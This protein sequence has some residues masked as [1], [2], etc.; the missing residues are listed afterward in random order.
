MLLGEYLIKHKKIDEE[1]LKIALDE[2]A[3]LTHHEKLGEV[4][5]KLGFIKRQVLIEA[6]SELDPTA[7]VG[8]KHGGTE[9]PREYLK[10]TR[11]VIRADAGR[12]IF[13]ST[14]HP[15]PQEVVDRLKKTTNREVRL[16]PAELEWMLDTCE[17]E[18]GSEH[19]EEEPVRSLVEETDINKVLRYIIETANKNRASDIHLDPTGSTLEVRLRIDTM[20]HHLASLTMSQA[21]SLIARIKGLA[22][23]MDEAQTRQ[24]QDGSFPFHCHGQNIDLRV[25][26]LP[27]LNGEKLTLRLLNKDKNLKRIEDVGLSKL[28]EWL[29]LAAQRNGLILVCGPTGSG[30]TTTL[31]STIEYQ[32]RQHKAVF[33]IEDPIEYQLPFVTQV[34]INPDMGMTFNSFTKY[35]MRHDP[36]MVVVGE[37]RDKETAD[38]SIYLATTGH[39]VYSTLHTG[40]VSESINRLLGMEVDKQLLSFVLRGILVQCLVRRICPDC[41]KKIHEDGKVGCSTCQHTGYAGMSLLTE[42]ARL[43]THEDVDRIL[44]GEL[45]IYTYAQD[46]IAKVAAGVT[47]CEEIR[48]VFGKRDFHAC[49][50]GECLVGSE[51]NVKRRAA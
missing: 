20:V 46:A 30:K 49:G 24:A 38:N 41:R 36:D 2:Q 6:L 39:L 15:N 44:N 1:K 4:L 29:D 10:A 43:H 19:L 11:T 27:A 17:E 45:D 34:Q 40:S 13:I 51:C 48:R 22:D 7:L 33:T 35:V 12:Y 5:I 16:Q 3:A 8:D 9:F 18:Y 25:A 23:T 28:P 42:F 21:T 31:Y 26:S 50:G 14:L 47:D 37:I 32:D